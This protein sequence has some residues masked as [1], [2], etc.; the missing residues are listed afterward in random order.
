MWY[1]VWI[2]WAL[3][4][5]ARIIARI[6][7]SALGIHRKEEHRFAVID[8]FTPASCGDLL[9]AI[10]SLK[11]DTLY[12]ER[13][14]F[15]KIHIDDFLNTATLS[16]Y[17]FSIIQY[18]ICNLLIQPRRKVFGFCWTPFFIPSRPHYLIVPFLSFPKILI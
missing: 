13:F 12:L 7:S 3:L 4:V 10:L 9:S 1:L 5:C 17:F 11:E 16:Y 6:D 8:Q 18:I 2:C 15:P 14:N